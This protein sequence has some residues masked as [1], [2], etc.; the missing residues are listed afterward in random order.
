MITLH[1]GTLQKQSVM[2]FHCCA[3][4]SLATFQMLNVP[5]NARWMGRVC[6]L[7]SPTIVMCWYKWSRSVWFCEWMK[8]S[9]AICRVKWSTAIISLIKAAFLDWSALIISISSFSPLV[10]FLIYTQ[11]PR[12]LSVCP[13]FSPGFWVHGWMDGCSALLFLEGPQC[14]FESCCKQQKHQKSKIC[15]GLVGLS[16][17]HFFCLVLGS[18]FK[19]KA[20]GDLLRD[21]G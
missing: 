18:T 13:V 7:Q 19:T 9:E 20:G 21:L 11:R 4:L 1:S 10:L 16:E 6:C 15:L 14:V 17:M 5:T 12:K 3:Y 8:S 2:L